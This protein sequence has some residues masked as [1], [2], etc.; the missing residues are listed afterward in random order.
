MNPQE[1]QLIEEFKSRLEGKISLTLVDAYLE[2]PG[3]ESIVA[4]AIEILEYAT[5]KP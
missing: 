1:R 2:K 3:S 5:K 4:R